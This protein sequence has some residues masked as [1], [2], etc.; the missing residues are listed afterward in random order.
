GPDAEIAALPRRFPRAPASEDV[1]ADA[2]DWSKGDESAQ[3]EVPWSVG[4]RSG[5]RPSHSSLPAPSPRLSQALSTGVAAV[6]SNT[7]H[8]YSTHRSPRLP[9]LLSRTGRE[10]AW[11]RPL[12]VGRFDFP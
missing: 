4:E 8:A 10:L 9:V 2:G 1:N 11:V 3:R 6:L 12:G 5:N 7:A